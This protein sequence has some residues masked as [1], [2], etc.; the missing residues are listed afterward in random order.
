MSGLD[1][2]EKVEIFKG[3]NHDQLNA[4]KKGGRE[5]EYLFGDRLFA[6]GEDADRI[7]L[8]LDGQVDL[9]FDLPGRLTQLFEDDAELGDKVMSK[10]MIVGGQRFHQ[11]Q[12]EVARRRGHDI[13]N[14]W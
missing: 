4:V 5:K 8:V 12:D 1:I 9:R 10:V 7:W 2:L 11:F 14:R 13:I 3:L 6:E